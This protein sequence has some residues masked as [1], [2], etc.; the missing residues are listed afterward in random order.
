M[1]Y[2]KRWLFAHNR[3]NIKTHLHIQ[4]KHTHIGIC[5]THRIANFLFGYSLFTLAD[6]PGYISKDAKECPMCKAGEKITAIA[7]SYGLSKL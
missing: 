7:N 2:L 3:H 5:R 1:L 4:L 6:L